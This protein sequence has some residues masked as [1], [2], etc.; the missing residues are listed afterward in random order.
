ML[1]IISL[2]I[3]LTLTV[4]PIL[5]GCAMRTVTPDTQFEKMIGA[6][7]DSSVRLVTSQKAYH[8]MEAISYQVINNTEQPLFFNDQ[9]MGV[10]GYQYNPQTQQW[11][12]V[13]LGFFV[14]D[15]HPTIVLPSKQATE[16]AVYSLPIFRIKASGD[17]RLVAKGRLA[18]MIQMLKSQLLQ[19]YASTKIIQS[20]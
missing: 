11:E 3:G 7:F 15:P 20:S 5:A 6:P 10:A 4:L 2:S 1:R 16:V 8:A 13:D 9:S 19:I 12:S 17:I 14:G 18:Q